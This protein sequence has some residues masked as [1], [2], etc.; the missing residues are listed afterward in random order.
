MGVD[1]DERFRKA[2]KFV[3]VQLVDEIKNIIWYSILF[4][5]FLNINLFTIIIIHNSSWLPA[6]PIVE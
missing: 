2:M 6:K 4:S 1:I 3:D 5:F